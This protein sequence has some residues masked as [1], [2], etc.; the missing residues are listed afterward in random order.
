ML[1][2]STCVPKAR[3]I[4]MMIC[5]SRPHQP[6]NS[7]LS[8]SSPSSSP[9]RM[10]FEPAADHGPQS[11]PRTTDLRTFRGPRTSE[12][13]VASRTASRTANHQRSRAEWTSDKRTSDHH[14]VGGTCESSSKCS[15]L[16]S[17]PG[18][19]NSNAFAAASPCA[20]AIASSWISE[21]AS[22]SMHD[23]ATETCDTQKSSCTACTECKS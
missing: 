9:M 17:E 18:M 2:G 13:T 6:S 4:Q 5:K 8:S 16:E 20:G 21:D 7:P 14:G 10:H 19:G 15:Q 1:C 3:M 23:D 12:P 11:L 22:A